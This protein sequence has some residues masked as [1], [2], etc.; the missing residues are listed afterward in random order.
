MKQLRFFAVEKDLLL[1]LMEIEKA[2]PLL[3]VQSDSDSAAVD[4]ITTCAELPSTGIATKESAVNSISFVVANRSTTIKTRQI[5]LNSG[6]VRYRVDQLENPDTVVLTPGGVW[7]ADV[8]LYGMVGTASDSQVSKALMKSLERE[9]KKRFTKVKA[10]WVGPKAL[11]MLKQGKRLTIA[12][13]SPKE[14]DLTLS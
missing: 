1:V 8:V 4:S 9:L 10:Y 7:D 13:Q 3:Y 6:A 5:R 2:M 11:E 14:F 12:A